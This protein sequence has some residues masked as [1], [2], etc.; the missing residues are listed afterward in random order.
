VVDSKGSAASGDT[1]QAGRTRRRGRSKARTLISL[2][3]SN[4]QD[5]ILGG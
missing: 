2:D 3:D 1:R 4:G 5:S